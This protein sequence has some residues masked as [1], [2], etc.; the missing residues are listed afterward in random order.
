MNFRIGR[1]KDEMVCDIV[2]MNAC[3]V[4][5]GQPWIWD[6]EDIHNGSD[7]TYS[8]IKDGKEYGLNPLQDKQEE[9]IKEIAA[10]FPNEC[11]KEESNIKVTIGEKEVVENHLKDEEKKKILQQI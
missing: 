8:I 5:L 6:R 9:V 1:Y 3:H 2:P 4:L 11:M 7:N 10:V